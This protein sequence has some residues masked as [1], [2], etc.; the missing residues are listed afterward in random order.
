M[1]R[2][3]EKASRWYSRARS[4]P[5]TLSVSISSNNPY[6]HIFIGY[7]HSMASRIEA[8]DLKAKLA[9]SS[10]DTLLYEVFQPAGISTVISWP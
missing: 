8:F 2:V 1:R 5:L 6:N 7:L 3:V 10:N 9:V 4:L